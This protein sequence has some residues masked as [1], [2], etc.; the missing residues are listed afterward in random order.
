[1]LQVQAL[2]T[3]II[4]LLIQFMQQPQQSNYPTNIPA[5]S[6]D[7][8]TLF[9]R[10]QVYQDMTLLQYVS[11][12]YRFEGQMCLYFQG[13]KSP[14]C[15][16]PLRR[17]NN[18]SLKCWEPFNHR[19]NIYPRGPKTQHICL[20]TSVPSSHLSPFQLYKLGWKKFIFQKVKIFL[21]KNFQ[22]TYGILPPVKKRQ[23]HNK[24]CLISTCQQDSQRIK[25]YIHPIH[26]HSIV[27]G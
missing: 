17:K 16:G 15:P 6:E 26:P 21:C 11:G 3:A 4:P 25:H 14:T 24:R 23:E 2:F 8:T 10:I 27:L 19:H 9:L 22:I 1:M 13:S 20:I 7:L 12:S 5:R 18:L